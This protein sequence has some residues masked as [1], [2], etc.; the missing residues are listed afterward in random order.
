MIDKKTLAKLDLKNLKT[1]SESE[2]IGNRDNVP[3]DVPM[4]NAAF[5]GDIDK[6]FYS[7]ITTI[8]GPSKHF[9]SLFALI[10]MKS[11]FNKYPEAKAIF[12]DSEFGIP[13]DYFKMLG[14][15]TD[16][17]YHV[18]IVDTMEL[19]TAVTMHLDSMERGMKRFLMVDSLGGIASVKEVSDALEGENK[20]DMTRAKALTSFFRISTARLGKL[21]LP[22][23]IINHVYKTLE[24]YA[25]EIPKGGEGGILASDTLWLIS[26]RQQKEQ[27]DI[28]GYDFVIRAYKSRFIKDTVKIPITVLF[29]GGVSK[30]SG[31]LETAIAGGFVDNSSQ[32]YYAAVDLETGELGKKIRKRDTNNDEFWDPILASD[33]FKEYIRDTYQLNKKQSLL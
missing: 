10:A 7:G 25:K 24:V 11:Y 2:Y 5:S 30:Y 27:K 16:C 22:M 31:L 3:T 19:K 8:C 33:R 26:K 29:E 32:G 6:G 9:K 4:L 17:V 14:I 20:T 18:P 21:D 23:F 13:E 12:Y 1:V 28:I 15:D